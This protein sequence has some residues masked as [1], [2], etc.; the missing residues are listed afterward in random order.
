MAMEAPESSDFENKD[1]VKAMAKYHNQTRWI[2]IS[3]F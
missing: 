3:M 1:K 2:N